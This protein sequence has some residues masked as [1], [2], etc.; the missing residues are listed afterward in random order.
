MN[1]TMICEN[2]EG[3]KETMVDD[4]LVEDSEEKL[5]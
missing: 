1:E 5:S 2:K 4:S 3:D